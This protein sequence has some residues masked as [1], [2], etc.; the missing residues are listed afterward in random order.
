MTAKDIIK[1]A[2]ERNALTEH[3]VNQRKGNTITKEYIINL[4][5]NI[6]TLTLNELLETL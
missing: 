3:I 5:I 6:N 4:I 2:S 1:F